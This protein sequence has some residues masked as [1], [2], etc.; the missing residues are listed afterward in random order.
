MALV[1]AIAN[2]LWKVKSSEKITLAFP[3]KGASKIDINNLR[4]L[5]FDANDFRTAFSGLWV[6]RDEFIGEKNFG[7]AALLYSVVLTKGSEK[8][9]EEVD[10][11]TSSLIGNHGHCTQ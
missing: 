7:V 6:S 11:K 4:V 1:G 5:T 9:E 8:I 2:I 3:P 10:V